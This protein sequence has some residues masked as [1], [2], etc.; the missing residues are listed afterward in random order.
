MN[1]PKGKHFYTAHVHLP[2]IRTDVIFGDDQHAA[3]AAHLSTHYTANATLADHEEEQLEAVLKRIAALLS[4]EKMPAL[5]QYHKSIEVAAE[6]WCCDIVC[7][8]PSCRIP[9]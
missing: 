2:N 8:S 9:D 3:L 7:C 4:K 6:Q 1:A 5:H